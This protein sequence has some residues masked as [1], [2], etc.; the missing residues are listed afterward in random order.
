MSLSLYPD[1][2]YTPEEWYKYCKM[3]QVYENET[4][5]RHWKFS[6]ISNKYCGVSHDKYLKIKQKPK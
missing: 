3:L 6:Y 4:P 1:T 5:E 2:N